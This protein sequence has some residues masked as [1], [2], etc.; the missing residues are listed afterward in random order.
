VHVL[1]SAPCGSSISGKTSP[2]IE[3]RMCT[4]LYPQYMSWS[5]AC[6]HSS[7]G[8]SNFRWGFW[9]Q[10]ICTWRSLATVNSD[11]YRKASYKSPW[12]F[13]VFHRSQALEALI[14]TGSVIPSLSS[15]F[16]SLYDAGSRVSTIAI[17]FSL[18][19][20]FAVLWNKWW[21]RC[22]METTRLEMQL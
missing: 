6:F 14:Y 10:Y 7:W 4:R 12:W 1:K 8:D 22:N 19:H 21:E 3:W 13:T 17:S 20:C 11:I 16:G 9:G 5:L 2:P 18:A 15:A